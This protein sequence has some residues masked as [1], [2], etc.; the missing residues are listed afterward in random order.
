[1]D[2]DTCFVAAAGDDVQVS[3]DWRVQVWVVLIVVVVVVVV[4]CM[5]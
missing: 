4:V 2:V 3:A 1:M 5:R